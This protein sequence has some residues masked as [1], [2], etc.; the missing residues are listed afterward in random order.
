MKE[1]VAVRFGNRV[2]YGKVMEG[3]LESSCIGT[4]FNPDS[5]SGS[6]LAEYYLTK[7]EWYKFSVM[8]CYFCQTFGDPL[9]A[10]RSYTQL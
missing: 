5:S 1:A 2:P 3:G 10:H 7:L 6:L 4:G 9:S 8:A